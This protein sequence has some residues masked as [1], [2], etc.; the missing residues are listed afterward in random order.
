MSEVS[1]TGTFELVAVDECVKLEEPLFVAFNPKG[2]NPLFRIMSE[3]IKISRTS[4][5]QAENKLLNKTHFVL[6]LT[7]PAMDLEAAERAFRILSKLAE[8]PANPIKTFHKKQ[9][10][11]KSAPV[12]RG[13]RIVSKQ[14]SR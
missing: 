5:E 3:R 4:L 8:E 9:T 11:G 14:N 7:A 6:D 10:P 13:K 1:H 12:R 2:T